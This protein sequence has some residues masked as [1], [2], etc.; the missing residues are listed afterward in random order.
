MDVAK[1]RLVQ[2]L[3]RDR[4]EAAA[5]GSSIAMTRESAG[6]ADEHDLAAAVDQL[7]AMGFSPQHVQL[8]YERC[9]TA[10][11]AGGGCGG[12]GSSSNGPVGL[13]ALLDWLLINL[14]ADQLPGQFTKGIGFRGRDERHWF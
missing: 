6:A 3:L 4:A 11:S 7:S 13:E 9:S 2:A 1:Q 14:P 8:A 10:A 12:D 5:L